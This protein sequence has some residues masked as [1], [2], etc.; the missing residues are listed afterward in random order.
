MVMAQVFILFIMKR[1]EA[2]K[3]EIGAPFVALE[4]SNVVSYHDSIVIYKRVKEGLSR[5]FYPERKN[6]QSLLEIFMMGVL[7]KLCCF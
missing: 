7:T 2:K 6:E 3:N 5:A 4:R 1:K